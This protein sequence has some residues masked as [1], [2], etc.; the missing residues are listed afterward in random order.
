[1]PGWDENNDDQM[2][3]CVCGKKCKGRRGLRKHQYTC[4]I[5]KLLPDKCR[6][7]INPDGP[8]SDTPPDPSQ[9]IPQ[10]DPCVTQE[11]ITPDYWPSN[12]SHGDQPFLLNV[13]HGDARLELHRATS[14]KVH[15]YSI[16]CQQ[17]IEMLMFIA[18]DV[19]SAQTLINLNVAWCKW[20]GMHLQIDKCVSFGM[21]K[22]EGVYTQYLPNLTI[23][24]SK[25]PALELG[26]SFKYLGKLFNFEW[27]TMKRSLL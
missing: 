22:Q 20:S 19:K 5:E 8:T 16:I 2:I 6:D 7:L 1:M 10:D 25:I 27:T 26:S 9:D 3:S 21:R 15:S 11:T 18:N 4:R 17:I 24:D 12:H 14:I 13:T 23:N